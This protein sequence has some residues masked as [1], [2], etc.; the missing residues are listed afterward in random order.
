MAKQP[1]E[2]LSFE[3]TLTFFIKRIGSETYHT[4][5]ALVTRPT[6]E[7]HLKSLYHN[8][9]V[10]TVWLY[11][12][13]FRSIWKFTLYCCGVCCSLTQKLNW[14]LFQFLDLNTIHLKLGI[15]SMLTNYVNNGWLKFFWNCSVEWPSHINY[16]EEW[17]HTLVW[18][19][20]VTHFL[21]YNTIIWI[22]EYVLPL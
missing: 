5:M 19:K 14:F 2:G 20:F 3:T 4:T 15:K 17:K 12:N 7:Q 21:Y 6:K 10:L 11:V 16:I 22:S 1:M 18:M 13:N 8:F 9:Q